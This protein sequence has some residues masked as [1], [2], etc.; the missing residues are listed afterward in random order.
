MKQKKRFV[1]RGF[2]NILKNM[3][4]VQKPIVPEFIRI[5]IDP[6]RGG[7]VCYMDAQTALAKPDKRYTNQVLAL[8][9]IESG[10]ATYIVDDKIA[11][12]PAFS[13]IWLFPDQKRS[14][15][16]RTPDFKMWVI[17]FTQDF[18]LRSCTEQHDEILKQQ[19]G[20]IPHRQLPAHEFRFIR[21][22]LI[23]LR[24]LGT[25]ASPSPR[26]H[27][28]ENDLF[29]AGLHY[30]LQ[31]CWHIFCTTKSTLCSSELP[32]SIVKAVHIICSEKDEGLPIPELARHCGISTSRLTCL[33]RKEI[34]AT[35]TQFRNQQKLKRFFSLY[36]QT[37]SANITTCALNA[38]FGSYTQFY[39]V[40]KQTVGISPIEYSSKN[41]AL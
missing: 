31:H 18:L 16:R 30:I 13:A 41:S 10:S 4:G 40:F 39:T 9:V 3:S 1:I 22:I 15:C 35:I 34:G 32:P 5:P 24:K 29:N 8:L 7:R 26:R 28:N 17:Q 20:E 25:P 19:H 38:G 37:G 27:Q 2:S 33:F 14:L 21:Q 36:S 12:L 23:E 6:E 11:E